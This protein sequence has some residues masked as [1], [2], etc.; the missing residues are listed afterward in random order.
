MNGSLGDIHV[1]LHQKPQTL[2]IRIAVLAKSPDTTW[3]NLCVG[4]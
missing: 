2:R 1:P 4:I 3:P